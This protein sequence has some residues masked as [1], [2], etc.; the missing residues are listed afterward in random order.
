[1]SNATC[2]LAHPTAKNGK[3]MRL[4]LY[5]TGIVED[6]SNDSLFK[7]AKKKTYPAGIIG[8]NG[9]GYMGR[10]IL[11]RMANGW[12]MKQESEELS[13]DRYS[14]NAS[15]SDDRHLKAVTGLMVPTKDHER[16]AAGEAILSKHLLV[17]ASRAGQTTVI[18]CMFVRSEL[19]VE[20]ATLLSLVARTGLDPSLSNFLGDFDSPN[21]VFQQ[22]RNFESLGDDC[23]DRLETIGISLRV[24]DYRKLASANSA[25]VGF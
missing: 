7:N 5:D 4:T 8:N 10:L 9:I 13:R 22:L 2:T 3:Y 25:F 20:R 24:T 1:M 12:T 11:D 14:L 21:K 19:D 16:L 17:T 18:T 6:L 23:L 15:I